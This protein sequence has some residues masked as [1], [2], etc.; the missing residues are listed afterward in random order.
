MATKARPGVTVIQEV[1]PASPSSITP[2]LNPCIIGPCYAITEPLTSSGALD[3]RSQIKSPARVTGSATVGDVLPIAA[4]FLGISVDSG[5]IITFQLPAVA[6]GA[7]LNTAEVPAAIRAAVS[8]LNARLIGVSGAWTLVL[9]SQTTGDTSKIKLWSNAELVTLGILTGAETMAYASLQLTASVDLETLVGKTSYKNARYVMP[10][11]LLPTLEFHPG[12]DELVFDSDELDVHKKSGIVLT[13]LSKSAATNWTSLLSFRTDI[14]GVN[15]VTSF[16]PIT[17]ARDSLYAKAGVGT[18]SGKAMHVGREASVYIPLSTNRLTGGFTY[19]GVTEVWPDASGTIYMYAEAKGAQ[20][21]KADQAQ[22]VGPRAGELGNDVV[23][24]FTAGGA[25]SVVWVAP[26]LTVNYIAASATR[27]IVKDLLIASADVSANFYSADL[28]FP[29]GTGGSLL[30]PNS[31]MHGRSWNLSGGIDPVSFAADGSNAAAIVVGAVNN[32]VVDPV[33]LLGG[34]S[35]TISVNGAEPVTVAMPTATPTS[36]QLASDITA[37]F[38]GGELTAVANA[39]IASKHDDSTTGTALKLTAVT[40]A[41]DTGHD[42]TVE[43]GGDQ[44]AIDLLFGGYLTR[45]DVLTGIASTGAMT[46]SLT[47][48]APG[49][50][51]YNVLA[52]TELEKA[53]SPNSVS[54]LFE[55][56]ALNAYIASG[57]FETNGGGDFMITAGL[58]AH[59]ITLKHS[60][61]HPNGGALGD[62]FDIVI[63]SAGAT[64]AQFVTAINTQINAAVPSGVTNN[65]DTFIEAVSIRTQDSTSNIHL[66]FRDMRPAGVNGTIEILGSVAGSTTAAFEAEFAASIPT[67][68]DNAVTSQTGT[69]TITDT[70]LRALMPMTAVPSVIYPGPSGF[71]ILNAS[72]TPVE[73][74]YS[75]GSVAARLEP[76][77][78]QSV[79]GTTGKITYTRGAANMVTREILDFTS[80]IQFGQSRQV[81]SGDKLYNNGAIVATVLKVETTT[82]TGAPAGWGTG[83]TLVLSANALDKGSSIA[84]WYIRAQNL[85]IT[86]S[87]R[88][89]P[90]VIADDVNQTVSMKHNLNR[91]PNGIPMIGAANLYADYRALRLDV[92]SEATSPGLLVFR[93]AEDMT[94]QIG[95]IDTRNPLAFAL[96]LGFDNAPTIELRAMGVAAVSANS[97][98]G[99]AQA[100]RDALNYLERHD[101]YALAALSQ[102]AAVGQLVYGHVRAMSDAGKGGERMAFFCPTLPVEESPDLVGSGSGVTIAAVSADVW[103]FEFD[104]TVNFAALMSGMT[105]ANGASI[106]TAVGS[107]FTAENGIFITREGDPFKYLVTKMVSASTLRVG[108]NYAFDATSGP[109]TA[110]ND[111]AYYISDDTEL[112]TFPSIGEVCTVS[113]RGVAIATNTTAGKLKQCESLADLA[114]SFASRRFHIKQPESIATTVDGLEV[115][116]P[117]FY[118]CAVTAAMKGQYNPSQPFTELPVSG[119]TRPIGSSDRFTESQMATAASGGIWWDIQDAPGNP[120]KSRHQLTTD[121]TSLKTQESSITSAIDALAKRVR[122]TVKRYTGRYNITKGLLRQIGLSLTSVL[123][124]AGGDIVAEARLVSI[125]VVESSL[126]SI[127]VVIGT[128]P[129]YPTNE[130]IVRIV[131]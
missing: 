44:E 32:A 85:P 117:G 108:T 72:A 121:L 75:V 42:C 17:A 55:G 96:S 107:T 22:P 70:P 81:K 47:Q 83:N 11:E 67:I 43:L 49:A 1:A 82:P 29:S 88:P 100:Y 113:I 89:R 61:Y 105:D 97:P 15:T 90:E 69:V 21:Y 26:T 103:D 131:I 9:T 33:S 60:G 30:D 64:V 31:A 8:G 118:H 94:S 34:K 36:A 106:P 73:V 91:G 115:I 123:A 65:A 95:P 99:T 23:I 68:F 128:T 24:L 10:Y 20:A 7:N 127:A 63:T 119:F 57:E 51:K 2:A 18:K 116:I 112:D 35:I 38:P 3:T 13:K 39:A 37:A 58:G 129:Y 54:V 79:A 109:G 56:V 110:G 102:E 122:N 52:N 45:T 59:T 71:E 104:N 101:V 27:Q 4:A 28:V 86:G 126:D 120:L 92:T 5:D 6:I 16:G 25:N 114:E 19:L 78:A 87:T 125:E 40:T 53:I 130:I 111:D 84:D 62:S 66:V 77:L 76:V 48:G 12:A 93:D 41:A 14:G 50:L 74:V 98:Y 46:Y 124:G 80:M